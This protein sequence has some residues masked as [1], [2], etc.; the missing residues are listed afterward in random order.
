VSAEELLSMPDDGFRYELVRGELRQMPPAGGEHGLVAVDAAT[1]LNQYVKAHNLGR[2]FAA[3]TGFKLASSPD[4]VRA[5]D[6]AFVR[7]ER[8]EQV[9]VTQGYWPGAPDLALEVIS[10]NDTYTEVF[11]K[12][13]AWL[14]AGTRLVLVADPRKRA[15]AVYRSLSDFD[16]LTEG[17]V[18]GGEVVPGWHMPLQ[19]IFR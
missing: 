4:T 13:S 5:P 10:P 14:N 17:E 16:I 2:V 18:D 9:G 1:S 6:V 8:F 11:E 7:R 12:V 15:V 19:D 3:E